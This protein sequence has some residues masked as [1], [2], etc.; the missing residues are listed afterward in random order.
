[1]SNEAIIE[2]HLASL[3]SRADYYVDLTEEYLGDLRS[4]ALNYQDLLDP[5]DMT[6]VAPSVTLTTEAT[7]ITCDFSS[8]LSYPSANDIL[9]TAI[10]GAYDSEF[11]EYLEQ[12]TKNTPLAAWGIALNSIR[13][14]YRDSVTVSATNYVTQFIPLPAAYQTANLALVN[15]AYGR[16]ESDFVSKWQ[17]IMNEFAI[18]LS[19]EMMQT[20]IKIEDVRERA[21][22]DMV[23]IYG[24]YNK[25]LLQK[26]QVDLEAKLKKIQEIRG[27]ITSAIESH[28]SSTTQT[29]SV[30]T[31]EF[32]KELLRIDK[33]LAEQADSVQRT[34][35]EW[36]LETARSAALTDFAKAAVSQSDLSKGTFTT[37]NSTSEG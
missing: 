17:M 2:S 3:K 37:Y 6:F 16:H 26:A 7:D 29:F 9:Q 34:N 28:V 35:T 12:A 14:V 31:L 30:Q 36:R 21:V 27:Y 13:E 22:G 33:Y 5:A 19:Q 20:G 15:D 11:L 18:E 1:M 25:A 4:A 10:A 32:Q 24:D 8:G 23:A